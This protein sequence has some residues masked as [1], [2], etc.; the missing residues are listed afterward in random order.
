MPKTRNFAAEYA[1]R[2]ARALAR[3]LTL[4]Q[5]R[6]HPRAGER[7]LRPI[8]FDGGLEAALKSM[9]GGSKL[10]DAAKVHSVS[11]ER[12]SRYIKSQAGAGRSGRAWTFNDQRRRR[13]QVIEAGQVVDIWVVGYEP[14]RLAG[15]YMVDAARVIGDPE[16]LGPRFVRT[17]ENVSIK[18]A[19]GRRH[20]FTTD[21]NE[22]YRA[23]HAND[24]PFEQ[25][26]KLVMAQ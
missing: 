12:L 4:S 21:L 18:S 17:W 9:R 14:A 10:K 22:I 26:Y 7:G 24:R 2:K 8:K 3:G 13:V 6:G 20:F 15:R 19:S 16:I 5:A 1:R 11:R 23:L 25:V